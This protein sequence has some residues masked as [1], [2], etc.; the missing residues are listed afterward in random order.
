MPFLGCQ[1]SRGRRKGRG[2]KKKRKR[3]EDEE[4]EEEDKK[5]AGDKEHPNAFFGLPKTHL[6]PMLERRAKR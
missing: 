5:Q 2:R 3:E 6:A 4:Q 1:T